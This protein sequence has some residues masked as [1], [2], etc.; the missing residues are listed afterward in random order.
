VPY[1]ASPAAVLSML[2]GDTHMASL[3]PLAV[4]PQVQAGK[5]KALAV[6]TRERSVFVPGVPTCREMGLPEI[7]ATAWLGVVVPARTPAPVI[8]RLNTEIV[9]ILKDPLVIEKLRAVYMEPAG[10]TPAA[11]AAFMQDELRRWGPVIRRSGASID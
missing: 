11:F 7:E 8:A 4:M 9:S 2:Q 10:G 6:T 5:L 3:A 1:N